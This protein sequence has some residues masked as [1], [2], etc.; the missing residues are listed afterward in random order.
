M[1]CPALAQV[2][3]PP[4]AKLPEGVHGGSQWLPADR[5]EVSPPQLL[6]LAEEDGEQLVQILGLRLL[7]ERRFDDLANVEASLGSA[8]HRVEAEPEPANLVQNWPWHGLAT[9]SLL[10]D[11]AGAMS[12][13]PMSR[14]FV[15]ALELRCVRGL[16]DLVRSTARPRSRAATRSGR[17]EQQSRR[18]AT[19]VRCYACNPLEAR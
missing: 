8:A 12:P 16:L 6:V 1:K 4:Q 9:F 11:K 10:D 15:H 2:G 19:I 5:V 7:C 18:G 14:S 13:T 3:A 17:L